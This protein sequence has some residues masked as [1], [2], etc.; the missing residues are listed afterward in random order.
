MAS[1]PQPTAKF[2]LVPALQRKVKYY[3]QLLIFCI[4]LLISWIASA[5]NNLTIPGNIT[6]PEVIPQTVPTGILKIITIPVD[7]AI[8]I[9]NQYAGS[10]LYYNT[11]FPAGIYRISFGAVSGYET[12]LNQTIN[13]SAANQTNIIVQYTT[14]KIT[15]PDVMITQET[16]MTSIAAD[17][18]IE[19]I[20]K[21][22]NNG[23]IKASGV[24]L[25]ESL[26]D[27]AV[28]L[29][30][31]KFSTFDLESGE[32]KIFTYEL[33]PSKT[34]LCIFDP[35]RVT[36]SDPAG[37]KFSKFSDEVKVLV[38]AKPS[39]EPHLVIDKNVDRYSALVDDGVAVTVKIKNDG[40]AK[41]SNVSLVDAIPACA[42]I[43]QGTNSWTGDLQPE[44]QK[45]ITYI[46]NLKLSGLCSF[47]AA[48]VS[49]SDAK[50]NNFTKYSEPLNI[51][52]KEKTVSEALDPAVKPI[53]MVGTV[54]GSIITIIT[55]YR[56]MKSKIKK[57]KDK[58]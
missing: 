58:K 18:P 56:A 38:Q 39:S 41:A 13:I 24:S 10:G 51:Y 5:E 33:M 53:I 46:V 8:S 27:C 11:S 25:N 35:S 31:E 17:E 16:P 48:K 14:F 3:R 22:K 19:L 26:P 44:E 29:K 30:E 45:V 28:P 42:V 12:P 43:S 49:Y 54:I 15:P 52:V 55:V 1:E 40:S 6:I 32:S 23:N 21:I 34:G 7:G 2:I 36:F 4:I 37:N 47:E 20:I 9:D 57:E 50:N